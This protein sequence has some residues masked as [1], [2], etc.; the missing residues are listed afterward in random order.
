M[1][2]VDGETENERDSESLPTL[3]RRERSSGHN[4]DAAAVV[5]L[6]SQQKDD[7]S[8]NRNADDH[9]RPER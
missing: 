7:G 9:E 8:G 5:V 6:S 2:Q 4:P 1:E 3:H